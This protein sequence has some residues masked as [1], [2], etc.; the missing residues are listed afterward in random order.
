MRVDFGSRKLKE[1]RQTP[2]FIDKDRRKDERRGKALR[3]ILQKRRKEFL[4][5][6]NAQR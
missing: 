3:D 6:I 2:C 1:R 5:H 4:R